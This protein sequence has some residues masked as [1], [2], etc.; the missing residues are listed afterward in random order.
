MRRACQTALAATALVLAWQAATVWY[1]RDGDWTA[2]FHTGAF[3]RVPP[4]LEAEQL[5]RI[6]GDPG[7]DGQFYHFIAHDPWMRRGFAPYVDNP[8]LRW[9]RILVPGLAWLAAAG[10]DGAIDVAYVAVTLAFVLAGS[11][12]LSLYCQEHGRRAA[13]GLLFPLIPGVLVSIDRM[14]IDT[15]IAALCVAFALYLRSPVRLWVVLA[16]APLARET[17]L[18]LVAG[19]CLWQR[20]RA[21]FYASAALPFLGWTAYVHA[22]TAPDH[23]A[24]LGWPF[25]GLVERTLHPV[26]FALSSRWLKQAAALDYL[27]LVGVWLALALI[28]RCAWR[29][30]AGP[31]ELALYC[32]AALA[33]TLAR[34][35]IWSGAYSFARTQT[36]LLVGLALLGLAS[37][38]WLLL[39]PLA[40]TI[41]RILFQFQPQWKGVLRGILSHVRSIA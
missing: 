40:L 2:L 5:H 18:C 15:A 33:V 7:Y 11:Y 6:A 38:S 23:T 24:W 27:A 14:T 32:L 20:K 30:S 1:N 28:A 8:R 25:A 36:P 31:L 29:R 10:Q 41:A 26:Q 9:R 17:G 12:W 13:W 21:A 16:L 39:A 34:A 22:R 19:A 4:P 35:D 3:A 37:R